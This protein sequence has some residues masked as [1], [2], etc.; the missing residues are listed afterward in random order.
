MQKCTTGKWLSIQ[1]DLIYKLP[2]RLRKISKDRQKANLMGTD[3]FSRTIEVYCL[4]P[5]PYLGLVHLRIKD[6][7]V[8]SACLTIQTFSLS[9]LLM[10]IDG[11]Q[12]FLPSP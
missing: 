6:G 11:T 12:Q 5:I 2:E 9:Y 4:F 1:T 10:P 7:L 8:Q 3:C